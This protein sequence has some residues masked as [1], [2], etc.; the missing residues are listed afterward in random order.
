MLH[1][2]KHNKVLHE[3]NIVLHVQ[4]EDVPLVT[5]AKR[6]EVTDLGHGFYRMIVRYGFMNAPDILKA[7]AHAKQ[8][9]IDFEMMDTSFFVSREVLVPNPARG[10]R[11]GGSAC[12]A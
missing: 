6:L 8:H 4:F 7:L 3:R 2:L 5:R 10:F 1:N 12:S 9:G 11:S